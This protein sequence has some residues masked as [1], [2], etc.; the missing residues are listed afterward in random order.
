[1]FI[2]I[3]LVELNPGNLFRMFFKDRRDESA[4]ATPLR[5]KVDGN[6]VTTVDLYR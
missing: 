5:P 4:R 3:H 2:N 1:M 6:S